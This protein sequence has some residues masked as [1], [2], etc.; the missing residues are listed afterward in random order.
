M[1]P[2]DAPPEN[3]TFFDVLVWPVGLTMLALLIFYAGWRIEVKGGKAPWKWLAMAPG[4]FALY[5]GILYVS[6]YQNPL[7]YSL[8]V[9]AGKK[10]MYA[11]YGAL[12][13]PLL[14]VAGIVFFHFFNHKLNL[15]TDDD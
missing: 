15:A 1:L 4:L 9:G 3:F 11:H 14:G 12:I 13:F 6:N 5:I 2:Q 7:Y 8:V 10:M